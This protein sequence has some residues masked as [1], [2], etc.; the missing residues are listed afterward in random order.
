[1][2]LAVRAGVVFRHPIGVTDTSVDRIFDR[3]R[4]MKQEKGPLVSL[5]EKYPRHRIKFPRAGG[6]E[7]SQSEAY[8]FVEEDG[9]DVRYRFHDYDKIY[10]TPGLYEQ[11][12]YDRLK[13]KSPE[14]VGEILNST[15]SANGHNI[16]ELRVLDL[17]AGNGIMGEVLKSYGVSRLIGADIIEEAKIS[18]DRDRPGVYDE[19]Y[20]AD[21]TAL[22]DDQLAELEGWSIDCLTSVAA[23]GFGDIPPDVFADGWPSTSRIRFWTNPTGPDFPDLSES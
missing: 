19:Y 7:L 16:N 18:A 9:E 20:V 11:T 17:G 1:M 3:G 14:K 13:C 10:R 15:L 12:F 5:I 2:Q 4:I 21:F 23:L 22:S 6:H 8:F